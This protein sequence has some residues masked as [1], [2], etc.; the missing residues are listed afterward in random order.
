MA[1]ALCLRA[2]DEDE[3]KKGD[4]ECTANFVELVNRMFDCLNVGN[5]TDGKRSRNPF[6]QPYR[7][8]SDFRLKVGVHCT[9]IYTRICL[10]VYT[11]TCILCAC[12]CIH[13]CI[14]SMRNNCYYIVARNGIPQV[15]GAVGDCSGRERALHR[16]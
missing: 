9:C 10:H 5:Y 3:T 1:H 15:L 2:K 16:C 11:C 14:P 12:T 6:K 4:M 13:V 8:A 7:S